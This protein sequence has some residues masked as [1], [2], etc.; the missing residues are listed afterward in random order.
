ML[1]KSQGLVL[2]SELVTNGDFSQG[3][4]GWTLT[5]SSVVNGAL[6]C[7]SATSVN[8]AVG[9]ITVTAGRTYLVSFTVSNYISGVIL[10]QLG[11]GTNVGTPL[12]SGNG[13]WTAKIVAGAG[14]SEVRMQCNNSGFIGTIDNISVKLLAGNH[15]TQATST[16]RPIYGINPITGT[17][18]LLTYTEQFDNAVWGKDS[19]TITTDVAVAPD[20][21]NS[22]D[23]AVV[24]NRILWFD[25]SGLTGFKTQS[26]YVKA[27]AG[28]VFTLTAIGGQ[29]IAGGST[30]TVNLTTGTVTSGQGSSVVVTSAGNGWWRIAAT[31]SVAT[32]SGNSTYWQIGATT[33]IYIWGAQLELGSTA[34]AYQKV[35][36]Q[37][38]VTEAGVQ[39]A[40][41]LA[42][43]GV[44]DGMVTGTI[45]PGIDKVQVF[46][47][48]R[49]LSDSAVAILAELS[50]DVNSAIG[51]FLLAAPGSGLGNIN[52]RIKGTLESGE[53][54]ATVSS[55]NTRVVTLT[56][57]IA[58][59][60][61]K[62]RLNASD[63]AAFSGSLGTGNFLAYP[64]YIGRRGG[65]SLPFNGRIYS[66]ITRF[67]A[68]LTTGQITSTESWVNSKTGAY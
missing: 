12:F 27:E 61:G 56:A 59:S 53:F 55:P 26:L 41:Y 5:S 58:G 18:N 15:A 47:G 64:L 11:V 13:V 17:R 1:D 63:A 4:T 22:A 39:S 44:D 7:S 14:N 62:L 31:A 50:A 45:T 36:S 21:T 57:D 68:N 65:V 10:L 40:S 38:E 60:S 33:G 20:G 25:N 66:L 43:D 52:G 35:V 6:D 24:T 32:A 51:S 23:K 67:G 54:G 28:T 3:S 42:F 48:V 8:F 30:V 19:A 37:Y 34:T 16:Q 49:K 46:A 29:S 2:G 9:G